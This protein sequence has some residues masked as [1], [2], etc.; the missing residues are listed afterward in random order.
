MSVE[1]HVN[2]DC[3]DLERMITFYTEALGYE[4]HGVAG[5]QYASIV[6]REPALPK[7][8]FQRVPEQKQ[9]KNRVH[10]DLV[11]DDIEAEAS[12][13]VELGAT[14]VSAAPVTEYDCSWIVMH[15]PEGNELCLCDG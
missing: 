15:D 14:R 5:D 1:L 10:L 6:S 8:V 13:W 12:R 11:V 3:H 9:A 2:I 7:I 4:R